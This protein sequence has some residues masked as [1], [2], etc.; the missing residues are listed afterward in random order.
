MTKDEILKKLMELPS[1]AWYTEEEAKEQREP[2]SGVYLLL[3]RQRIFL[4]KLLKECEC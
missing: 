4:E 2:F 3:V 1:G